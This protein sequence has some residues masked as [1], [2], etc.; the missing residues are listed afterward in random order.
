MKMEM[1]IRTMMDVPPAQQVGG[2]RWEPSFQAG[3]LPPGLSPGGRPVQ[4]R[5][6]HGFRLLGQVPEFRRGGRTGSGSR[7][8]P[9]GR[10][11]ARLPRVEW[12]RT[13]CHSTGRLVVEE[14]QL[15]RDRVRVGAVDGRVDQRVRGRVA[16]A[17]SWPDPLVLKSPNEVG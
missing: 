15:V 9:A 4:E 6:A 5:S 1:P 3:G 11:D 16:V 10:R 17:P 2:H 7:T 14:G 12:S 8:P 13:G